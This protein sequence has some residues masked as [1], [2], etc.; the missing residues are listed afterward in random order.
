MNYLDIFFLVIVIYFAILGLK[1]GIIKSIGGILSIVVG[2]YGASLFYQRV[3]IFLQGISG[4]FT[5]TIANIISFILLFIVIN[6]LFML[7]INILDKIFSL[8]IVGFFNKFL[9]AIF[10]FFAGILIVGI[11]V[12]VISSFSGDNVSYFENSKIVPKINTAI[13]FI[14]P[15]IPKNFN[16][17]FLENEWI[18][19]L[20]EIIQNL[21]DDIDNIDDL[22][23]YL[24]ERTNL[25]ENIIDNIKETQFKE[26]SNLNID[27][28]KSKLEEYIG[29]K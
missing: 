12:F 9:G 14:K 26:I 10:G 28:I 20:K 27:E 8:P 3:S 2:F 15:I 29:N 5:S 18:D 16:L 19:N 24:K 23:S 1:K 21:P 13:N 6:R 4:V 22:I 11:F 7:I 17:S 25:P